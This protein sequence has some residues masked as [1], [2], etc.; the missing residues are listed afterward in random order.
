VK[1]PAVKFLENPPDGGGAILCGRTDMKKILG[2]TKNV[3]TEDKSNS[4]LN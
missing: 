3:N 2:R 1:T 4:F